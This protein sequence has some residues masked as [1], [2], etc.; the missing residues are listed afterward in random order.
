MEECSS[1][2]EKTL[3]LL[4][5][6]PMVSHTKM[7][8]VSYPKITL[9]YII[10][11]DKRGG[12]IKTLTSMGDATNPPK[13]FSNERQWQKEEKAGCAQEE[14]EKVYAE[15]REKFSKCGRRRKG[16]RFL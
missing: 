8:Q 1:M 13:R 2:F 14:E 6:L 12:E 7:R 16:L 4:P 11:A 15:E 3:R 10:L 5:L 9:N